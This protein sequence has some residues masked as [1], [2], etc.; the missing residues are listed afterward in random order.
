MTSPYER[1]CRQTNFSEGGFVRKV[2]FLFF[3][4]FFILF[5]IFF[6]P[7]A[8]SSF[9]IMWVLGQLGFHLTTQWKGDGVLVCLIAGSI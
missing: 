8:L 3:P 5:F 4:T 1:A 7:I 6:W 9:F 2:P